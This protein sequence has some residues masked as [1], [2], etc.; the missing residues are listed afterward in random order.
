MEEI[1]ALLQDA[2]NE[3]FGSTSKASGSNLDTIDNLLQT[4]QRKLFCSVKPELPKDVV[5]VR[6]STVVKG[7]KRLNKMKRNLKRKDPLRHRYLKCSKGRFASKEGGWWE[8]G[9]I[10]SC[11]RAMLLT[12]DWAGLTRILLILVRDPKY[13][14]YVQHV[15]H[16]T[17]GG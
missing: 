6:K 12:K 7:L 16:L 10:E 5:Q 13:A 8:P 11:A 2:R 4:T 17:F 15:T 1:N 14:P 9:Y 3:M